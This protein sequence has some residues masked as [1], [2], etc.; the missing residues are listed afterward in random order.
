MLC[1]WR[2]PNPSRIAYTSSLWPHR[3]QE[4]ISTTKPSSAITSLE[5]YHYTK[6]KTIS[7][8]LSP[9]VNYTD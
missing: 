6:N 4:D 1:P 2:E 3:Y 8:A 7:V 9:Q 5:V